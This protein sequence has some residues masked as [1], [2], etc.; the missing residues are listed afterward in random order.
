MTYHFMHYFDQYNTYPLTDDRKLEIAKRRAIDN[1][2]QELMKNAV[3][4]I[5]KDGNV[6]GTLKIGDD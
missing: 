1:L 6:R 4:E 3:F 5:D 2:A